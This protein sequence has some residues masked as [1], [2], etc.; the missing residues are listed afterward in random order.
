MKML[1]ILLEAGLVPESMLCRTVL[2]V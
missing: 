2:I 1:S